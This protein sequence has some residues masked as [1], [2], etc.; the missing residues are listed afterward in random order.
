MILIEVRQIFR[1]LRPTNCIVRDNKCLFDIPMISEG[2]SRFVL[3][4]E[5]FKF[6]VL[7]SLC[8][9][10]IVLSFIYRLNVIN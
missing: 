3:R 1:E 2:Y 8:K 9:R 5:I 4:V 6:S 7:F 10:N